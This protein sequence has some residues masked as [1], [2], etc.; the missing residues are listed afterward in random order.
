[1]AVWVL[2][3]LHSRYIFLH[4]AVHS[5]HNPPSSILHSLANLQI[6]QLD[7]YRLTTA[8]S[9]LGQQNGA[10]NKGWVAADQDVGRTLTW[11]P[12]RAITWA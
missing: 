2:V 11:I 3:A 1:M 12:G 5:P 9:I 7:S 4:R 8:V 6:A 10:A